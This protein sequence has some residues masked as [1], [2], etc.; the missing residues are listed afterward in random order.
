MAV[1]TKSPHLSVVP[2]PFLTS[3]SACPSFKSDS[4]LDSPFF[5]V[6]MTICNEVATA[7]DGEHPHA[8]NITSNQ[9]ANDLL[10]IALQN[11][12]LLTV[13]TATRQ[14]IPWPW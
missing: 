11:G 13:D 7:E 6:G 9:Q 10:D 3:F 12:Y 1:I 8:I 4:P 2:L 5:P 14:L